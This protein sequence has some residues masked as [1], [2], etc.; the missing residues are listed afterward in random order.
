[1]SGTFRGFGEGLYEFFEDLEDNNERGW[2]HEHKARYEREVR[3]P[4]EAL[5]EDLRPA[6]GEAKLFRIHRD[7]RFSRDK[8]PYKTSQAGVIHRPGGS[9]LYLQV[10]ASGAMVGVGAPHLDRE[11]VERYR[12]AVAGPTGEQFAALVAD[13]RR[14]KYQVGVLS[15]DGIDPAGDL[16][17]VPAGF[18][19]DHPRGDLLRYKSVIAAVSSERPAWL[20]SGRGVAEVA[21]RW[22]A[23]LPLADWLD[24]HVGPAA[25]Q[26][27]RWR[28]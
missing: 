5:F 18:P 3:A 23:M 12:L 24:T 13:L 27:G 22:T 4:L 20:R 15:A 10:D 6:F 28:R 19:P 21:K 7:V 17:R 11:Q 25:P 8:S 1:M 2:F 16:K 26:E 14:R 9:T